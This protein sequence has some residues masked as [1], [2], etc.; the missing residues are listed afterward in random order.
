M[1]S[2]TN[3]TDIS[4]IECY[5][6]SRLHG[7]PLSTARFKSKMSDFVVEEHLRFELSGEG[8][9]HF[10]YIEKQNI[11]TDIVVQ[12][13]MRFAE[14]KPTDIGYA[15]KKDRFAIARQWFSVQLPL[16][17]EINW[18]EFNDDEVTV[19]DS[20]RHDKKLR[21]GAVKFNHFDIRLRDLD[22]DKE[23]FQKRLDNVISEGFPNYFGEQRFG[24]DGANLT[25]GID[26]LMKNKRLKNR[27]LQGLL[28]SAV[29]S[30]LYNHVVSERI[31]K[32]LSATLLD[33]D[34]VMLSGSE[35]GFVVEDLDAEQS[36]YTDNDILLTAPLAGSRPQPMN[37]A[38]TFE[39]DC[40]AKYQVLI[41]KLANKRFNEERRA[42][43]CFPQNVTSN[44]HNDTELTLSFDLPKGAFATS[45]LRE[46]V[47]LVET[48]TP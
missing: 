8:A 15:G 28:F 21:I 33:G 45:F 48:K 30:F 36:R 31:S 20:R 10:L 23:S 46:I 7:K 2:L 19:L 29:R 27:N 1:I 14:V 4:A 38:L 44:W 40:L 11:N 6:W 39:S 18:S 43:L 47:S 3:E 5:E 32:G 13:L 9:H 34:F 22:A 26:L 24:R 41:E 12:K 25:R 42:L 37:K 16:L 17:R 35:K